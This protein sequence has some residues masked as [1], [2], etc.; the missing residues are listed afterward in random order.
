[1]TAE[2]SKIGKVVEDQIVEFLRRTPQAAAVLAISFLSG[3]LWAYLVLVRRTSQKGTSLL[4]TIPAK[5]ALGLL[6]FSFVLV[7][8][9]GVSCRSLVFH[10]EKILGL[11][12]P[13]LVTGLFLQA[14][15]F[16]LATRTG[17]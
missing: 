3:Q 15:I 10:Y 9:Y 1:L 12:V 5:T 16:A 11:I 17:K 2:A 4:K 8:L 7:P 6:W 13:T 14:L